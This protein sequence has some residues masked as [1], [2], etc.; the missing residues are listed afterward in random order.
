MNE[1]KQQCI[2]KLKATGSHVTPEEVVTTANSDDVTP[3]SDPQATVL[4][5]SEVRTC[6]NCTS[7]NF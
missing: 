7:D 3:N 2:S 6:I 1:A 4:E 5:S